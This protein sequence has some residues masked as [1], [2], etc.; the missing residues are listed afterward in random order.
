M[1]IHV[2]PST[3]PPI[4][5][6]INLQAQQGGAEAEQA[7][8]ERMQ[9]MHEQAAVT[10]TLMVQALTVL[11]APMC[12]APLASATP[13]GA[14]AGGP[15]SQP[16]ASL[17]AGA[18]A[19]PATAAAASSGAAGIGPARS[20]STGA[21]A[22]GSAGGMA[23]ST[24]GSGGMRGGALSR[25]GAVSSQGPGPA[26]AAAAA[27]TAASA[28]LGAAAAA[29]T[30]LVAPVERLVVSGAWVSD[31]AAAQWCKSLKAMGDSC[32]LTDL[33]LS[34]T[35]LTWAGLADLVLGMCL[36]ICPACCD[37]PMLPKGRYA[38]RPKGLHR[39]A[40]RHSPGLVWPFATALAS[41]PQAAGAQ[42]VGAAGPSQAQLSLD[43]S[44]RAARA[45]KRLAENFGHLQCLDL[46]DCAG[47]LSCVAQCLDG[48]GWANM[49]GGEQ[50]LPE[51][52]A[53]VW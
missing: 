25:Q 34:H 48:A 43:L 35:S 17:S 44:R 39:L 31:A 9:A 26:G 47:E 42:A 38:P 20:V 10:T 37:H 5:H 32:R 33:D 22:G 6:T 1:G 30:R 28:G 24:L 45:C 3:F 11:L 14:A 16:A 46:R 7:E 40:V 53:I 12:C 52:A 8:V 49:L 51:A 27:V 50:V 4:A 29:V 23:V 19:G 13:A 41:P 15:R 36:C 21:G 2:T 18:V